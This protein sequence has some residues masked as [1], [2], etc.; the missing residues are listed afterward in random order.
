MIGIDQ[1]R[2]ADQDKVDPDPIV[3]KEPDPIVKK[4]PE[5]DNRKKHGS[6]RI[7]IRN[8]GFWIRQYPIESKV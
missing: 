2:V 5:S 1:G 6:E 3:K 7:R 4:K 8:P